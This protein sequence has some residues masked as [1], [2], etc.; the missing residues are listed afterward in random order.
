MEAQLD[1]NVRKVK[2]MASA[3]I[4]DFLDN[5]DDLTKAIKDVQAPEI[6]RVRAKVK[7]ALAAAK[8]A[9]SD[10][11]AQV[12]GQAKQVTKTTDTFVRDNP[13]Q[14]VGVAAVVGIALG[15]MM[16]RRSD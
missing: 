4:N 16:S 5:V 14:V 6:A 15:I 11:A 9:L 1:S 13:W 3:S 12:R 2:N 10:S 7:M 8:S